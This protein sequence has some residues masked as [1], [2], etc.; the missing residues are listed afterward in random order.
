MLSEPCPGNDY[1]LPHAAWLIDSYRRLTG[2]DLIDPE[3]LGRD[4]AQALYLAPFVVLSH[5][6]APDPRFT[7]ANL[8]AQDRFEMPWNEIVGMPSRFSAEPLARE[9]RDR[10]LARVAQCG[11]VDDY[12]GI[13]IA[14]SGRRFLSARAT[15]WSLSAPEGVWLGQ[16][17]MFSRWTDLATD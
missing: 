15:V 13:R 4:A 2:R 7:Y 1:L 8:A 12:S 14:R 9:A 3:R 5:D 11:F 17:A 6:A 16:A 10:L